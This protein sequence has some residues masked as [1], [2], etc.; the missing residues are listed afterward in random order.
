[1]EVLFWAVVQLQR[2]LAKGGGM[3]WVMED[4]KEGFQN[5]RWEVV[6]DRIRGT[7]AEGWLGWLKTFFR[8]REF[9]IK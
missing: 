5:I 6:R 7:V 4:I 8:K 9:T 1:M 2:C 3:V